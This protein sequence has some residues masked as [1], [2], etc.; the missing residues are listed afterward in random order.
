[1]FE[2][3]YDCLFD[4]LLGVEI[5]FIVV[6]QFCKDLIMFSLN[7]IIDN[8]REMLEC[9]DQQMSCEVSKYLNISRMS[10]ETCNFSQ[11]AVEKV[12]FVPVQLVVKL[13]HQ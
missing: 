11:L 13:A 7:F 6:T 1:M 10:T 5:N 3:K 2:F 12:H 4:I 8:G 9:W